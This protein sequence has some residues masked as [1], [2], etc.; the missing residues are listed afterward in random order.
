MQ[1]LKGTLEKKSSKTSRNFQRNIWS[2]SFSFFMPKQQPRP[3]NNLKEKWFFRLPVI[4]KRC[5]GD[6]V[7]Q[8]IC[9]FYL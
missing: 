8:N 1:P 3:Q 7:G 2:S 6:E 4:A 9:M 5:A